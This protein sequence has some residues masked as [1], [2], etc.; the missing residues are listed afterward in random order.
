MS[1]STLF[2]TL[3]VREGDV[4]AVVKEHWGLTLGDKLKASQNITFTAVDPVS[5]DKFA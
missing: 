3:N 1:S 2:E 5:G 4:A